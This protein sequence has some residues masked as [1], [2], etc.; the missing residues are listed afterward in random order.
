MAED[1]TTHYSEKSFW[2]KVSTYTK[3]IGSETLEKALVLYYVGMDPN[4]PVGAK[5]TIAA[6]LGYLICPVDAI[7]DFIPVGGYA[8]DAGALA[9]ALASVAMCITKEHRAAAKKKMDDWFGPTNS[10]HGPTDYP[11]IPQA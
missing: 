8:D 2:D 1:F 9:L 10:S 7:P 6:A 3:Q 5:L 4:T 11:R